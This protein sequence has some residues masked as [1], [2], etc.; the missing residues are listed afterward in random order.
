MIGSR[1]AVLLCFYWAEHCQCVTHSSNVYLKYAVV[2]I[3]SLN[4]CNMMQNDQLTI[5][6]YKISCPFNNTNRFK[7]V[8]VSVYIV[9]R[10]FFTNRKFRNVNHHAR[11]RSFSKRRHALSNRTFQI[12]AVQ[13]PLSQTFNTNAETG[14][15]WSPDSFV[16]VVFPPTLSSRTR[17]WYV[18]HCLTFLMHT[19]FS[20]CI[21]RYSKCF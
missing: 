8:K 13:W 10:A 19:M 6:P 21:C 16:R 1:V 7:K 14:Q 4:R 15:I 2:F 12:E 9:M 17:Q 11:Q 5:N 18:P 3:S 20:P